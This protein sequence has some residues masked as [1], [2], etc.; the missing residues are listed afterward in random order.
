MGESVVGGSGSTR[1]NS[2]ATSDRDAKIVTSPSTES[3]GLHRGGS[4][5]EA[6]EGINNI[7][8]SIRMGIN[9]AADD[10][11][12]AIAGRHSTHPTSSADATTTTSAPPPVPPRH[13]D[14]KV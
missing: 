7:G 2:Q 3:G 10:L 9:N 5:K 8:E 12:D 11:G 1:S 4:I 14:E 6:F 13:H